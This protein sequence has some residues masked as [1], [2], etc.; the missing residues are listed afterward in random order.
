MIYLHI[1]YIYYKYAPK[2]EP[3]QEFGMSFI[4]AFGFSCDT[5]YFEWFCSPTCLPYVTYKIIVIKRN[6]H[7]FKDINQLD[8]ISEVVSLLAICVK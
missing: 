7:I 4:L 6:K 2:R 8:I 5:L 1:I 3:Q